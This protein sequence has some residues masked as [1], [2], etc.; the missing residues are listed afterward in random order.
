[1][2]GQSETQLRQRI[3]DAV[4][5]QNA[6]RRAAEAAAKAGDLDHVEQCINGELEWAR[7][8]LTTVRRL[9]E[10]VAGVKNPQ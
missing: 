1:M 3:T 7:I 8:E 4:N 9:R 2:N 5:E 10:S 6:Y